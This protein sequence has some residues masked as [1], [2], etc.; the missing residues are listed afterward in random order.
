MRAK[1][2]Q[3]AVARL[4]TGEAIFDTEIRGFLVQANKAS[5]SYRLKTIIGRRQAMITIGTHGSPWTVEQAR[6]RALYLLSEIAGGRDPRIQAAGPSAITVAQL[7]E[8]FISQHAEAKKRSSSVSTDRKNLDNHIIPLL[9]STVVSELTANHIENF[10]LAVK[11]GRTRPPDPKAQ[12]KRQGGGL[13]VRGGPGV[14]NR[15]LTLLSTML[16]LAEHWGYRPKQSNPVRGITRFKESPRERYLI[17]S[18]IRRLFDTL[19]AAEATELPS[20]ILAIRLLMLTGARLS[21]ILTLEWNQLAPDCRTARLPQ[22]KT[23]AKTLVF[24]P[25]AASLLSA[26]PKVIDNPFVI[27]GGKRGSHLVDLQRPWQ[28][29]RRA[30]GIPDVRL[31]DL[32]HTFAS[33]AVMNGV[34]L[35]TVGELLGHTKPETTK[36]Y[37]HFNPETLHA[38]ASKVSEAFDRL[39][40]PKPSPTGRSY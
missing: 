29:V 38:A 9:G 15:C 27:P 40:A 20:A 5:K 14:A 24:P 35:T 7:A 12:L 23:G 21:E 10:K 34:P 22:S 1:I 25:M 33:M 16:N 3:A 32:R 30:A 18:E 36:R 28:R 6:R 31:H 26:A 37:A 11:A 2:T 19:D 4:G 13:L 39:A 8:L 17:E